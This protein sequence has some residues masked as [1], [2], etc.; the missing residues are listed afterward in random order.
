MGGSRVGLCLGSWVSFR[1]ILVQ[2]RFVGAGRGK[3]AQLGPP[4]NWLAVSPRDAPTGAKDAP[5]SQCQAGEESAALRYRPVLAMSEE[6]NLP[7]ISIKWEVFLKMPWRPYYRFGSTFLQILLQSLAGLP[8]RRIKSSLSLRLQKD[9]SCFPRQPSPIPEGEGGWQGPTE[10]LTGRV[11]ATPQ[12]SHLWGRPG[13]LSPAGAD[14]PCGN[15]ARGREMLSFEIWK[16][17][18]LFPLGFLGFSTLV[19]GRFHFSPQAA[20]GPACRS[21]FHLRGVPG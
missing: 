12:T 19:S 13:R 14:V 10:L 17:H 9:W 6:K 11:G 2:G 15:P 4:E 20:G 3:A 21:F 18:L 7:V 1:D 8:Y 5:A 16:Q